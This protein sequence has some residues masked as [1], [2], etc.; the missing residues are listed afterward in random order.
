MRFFIINAQ[1]GIG[2]DEA[3]YPTQSLIKYYE[4]GAEAARVARIITENTGYKHSVRQV[5]A[6]VNWQAREQS[7]FVTGEH[8]APAWLK[9]S[10]LA[11]NPEH[12]LHVSKKDP[13]KLAFTE[14][15][16]KGA[17]DI[18]TV[19]RVG[20]YLSRFHGSELSE[21]RLQELCHA[22][23][24]AHCERAHLLQFTKDSDEIVSLYREGHFLKELNSN[25]DEC[26]PLRSCMSHE[27]DYYRSS[28]HPLSVYGGGSDLSLAYVRDQAS[29]ELIARAIVW[30][31]EKK[32]SRAYGSNRL[33]IEGMRALL[34][35]EGYNR[36]GLLGAR[37]KRLFCDR[38]RDYV[39]PYLDGEQYVKASTGGHFFEICDESE[40]ELIAHS[41]SGFG[42][43]HE[44]QARVECDNCEEM[45]NE[46]ELYTVY[47]SSRYSQSWCYS[48]AHEST[49]TCQG[50]GARVSD[51]CCEEVDGELYADWYVERNANYCDEREEHTFETVFPVLALGLEIVTL[52]YSESALA[53]VLG[54]GLFFVCRL[55]GQNITQ[56]LAH[57]DPWHSEPRLVSIMPTDQP[58]GYSGS[59]FVRDYQDG[60]EFTFNIRNAA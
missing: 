26:F 31:A 13:S 10:G 9:S 32:Y 48:C 29:R 23:T 27:V 25:G 19:I 37:I 51:R 17:R 16:E 40:A 15:E 12:F 6:G 50:T 28:I 41:T 14:N 8:V 34:A 20:A 7:R 43:E 47:T 42:D 24:T 22:H 45:T 55:S 5:L 58:E 1:T 3:G 11:I 46:D 57:F 38:E 2:V 35:S 59:I 54:D 53:R 30:E 52:R 4:T 18:Q 44:E 60:K 21:A 39:L 33:S 36:E 56:E 49:F